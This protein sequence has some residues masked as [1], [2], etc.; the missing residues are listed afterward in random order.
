MSLLYVR[1][2]FPLSFGVCAIFPFSPLHPKWYGETFSTPRAGR[3]LSVEFL[4]E[5]L[6][7]R[8]VDSLFVLFMDGWRHRLLT[9]DYANHPCR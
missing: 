7:L 1:N 4:F 3:I 5:S 9:P 2:A 8:P 6:S